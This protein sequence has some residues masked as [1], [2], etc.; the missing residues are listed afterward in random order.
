MSGFPR[1]HRTPPCGRGPTAFPHSGKSQRDPRN[2][3]LG[4]PNAKRSSATPTNPPAS[5]FDAAVEGTAVPG[6]FS[7]QRSPPSC[8]HFEDPRGSRSCRERRYVQIRHRV[9]HTFAGWTAGINHRSAETL[10]S[11]RTGARRN[12]HSEPV[13]LAFSIRLE[14]LHHAKR[15]AQGK[16]CIGIG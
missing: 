12:G 9:Y 7:R 11:G 15:R 5:P 14:A 10:H 13:E 4:R 6:L 2:R 16:G 8:S 1:Q 3:E